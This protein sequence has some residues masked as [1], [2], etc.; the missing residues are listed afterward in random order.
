MT[1]KLMALAAI[2]AIAVSSSMQAQT[3]GTSHA[4]SVLADVSKRHPDVREMELIARRGDGCVTVAATDKGDIGDSCDRKERQVL[5]DGAALVEAPSRRDPVYIITEQLHDAQGAVIGLIITDLVPRG[6]AREAVLAR[7]AAIRSEVESQIGSAAQLAGNARTD[8][9]QTVD[10]SFAPRLDASRFVSAV[11]NQ[12]FPLVPGTTLRYRGT[13]RASNETTVTTVTNDTRMIMGIRAVVVHD[14]VFVGEVLKEDTFDW[15]AQDADGTVWYM[16]ED[17]KEYRDGRVASNEGSWEAG[18]N[19]AQ[20]GVMMWADPAAHLGATYRQEYLAG[21]AEDMG[22]VI[23]VSASV[24]TPYGKFDGCVETEDTSPLEP[25]VRGRK[26][27]CRGVG[28]VK[29]VE[30]A[31]ETSELVAVRRP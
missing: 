14:Q 4:Q 13:G 8:R 6:E 20:P 2:A 1:Q 12:F 26:F 17:T 21:V 5:R 28:I 30:S 10:A 31:N 22:K 18:V 25:N 11:T 3:P 24:S 16:G 23:G 19:G 7:A 27:Y 9:Q 15:Y 29:E